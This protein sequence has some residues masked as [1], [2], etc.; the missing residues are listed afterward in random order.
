MVGDNYRACLVFLGHM[1]C[2]NCRSLQRQGGANYAIGEAEGGKGC[3][4]PQAP[5]GLTV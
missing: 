1:L 4:L 2:P 3:V 5:W